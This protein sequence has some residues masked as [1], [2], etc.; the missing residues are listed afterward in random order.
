MVGDFSQLGQAIFKKTGDSTL[1]PG[2]PENIVAEHIVP[3]AMK[4]L[5]IVTPNLA[6]YIDYDVFLRDLMVLLCIYKYMGVKK[7]WCLHYGM[8]E[9]HNALHWLF[10]NWASIITID[11]LDCEK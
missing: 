7:V 6:Q 1:I 9:V 4:I 11:C 2:L 5:M 8:G 3:T 10:L